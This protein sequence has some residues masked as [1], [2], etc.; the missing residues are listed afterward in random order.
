MSL[1]WMLIAPAY[2]RMSRSS[3]EA[4]LGAMRQGLLAEASGRVVEIG[5][6]TGVNLPYYGEGVESLV[7]TDPE[8]PMLRRLQ[9]AANEHRPGSRVLQAPAEELP[10]ADSSFDV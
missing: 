10:F 5:S 9:R 7:L 6:G 2:D 8:P 3:E 1:R 4:G